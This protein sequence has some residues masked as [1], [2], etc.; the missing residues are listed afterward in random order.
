MQ[1]AIISLNIGVNL[2]Y[3]VHENVKLV[4]TKVKEFL[5][6]RRQRRKDMSVKIQPEPGAN[7]GKSRFQDITSTTM[8]MNHSFDAAAQSNITCGLGDFR[9]PLKTIEPPISL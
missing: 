5:E 1:I 7:L 3:F 8:I 4:Y 9:D 6:R 2:G